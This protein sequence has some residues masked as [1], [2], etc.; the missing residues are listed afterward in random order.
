MAVNRGTE[1]YDLSLFEPRP[2]K[3]VDIKTDKRLK[4]AQKH[5]NAVQAFLNAAVKLC[6][7]SMIVAS[8]GLMIGCRVKLTE[9]D[10][11]ISGCKQKI[12]ILQSEKTRLSGELAG[13]VST[14]SVQQYAEKVLG[15]QKIE[16]NQIEY[17]PADSGDKVVAAHA[18][19]PSILDTFGSS[20]KK[21]FSQLAYLFE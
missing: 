11:Q 18:T 9:M 5:Q 16:A 1:A 21:F 10:N 2:A 3:I 19:N 6:I 8:I 12:V 20:I 7:A 4:K 14:E 17:I 15:M 13:K